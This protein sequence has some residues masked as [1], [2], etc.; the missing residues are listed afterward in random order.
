MQAGTLRNLVTIQ[1]EQGT[2]RTP[3]GGRVPKWVT[4]GQTWASIKALAAHDVW[5]AHEAQSEQPVEIRTRYLSEFA[6]LTG[7]VRV[8]FGERS[9]H[10]VDSN[11]VFER[12]R[13]LVLGCTEAPDKA[14]GVAPPPYYE[15]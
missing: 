2:I 4:L 15:E 12:G 9:F 10:L 13:E 7:S 5:F 14:A 6:D 8:L 3:N 1:Q 11:N